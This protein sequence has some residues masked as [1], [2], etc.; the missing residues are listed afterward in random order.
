MKKRPGLA[1]L[2][3]FGDFYLVT[4]STCKIEALLGVV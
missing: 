2:Q 3:T 4:L 1:H